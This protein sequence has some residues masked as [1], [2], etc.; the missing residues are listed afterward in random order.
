MAL[1]LAGE[2][3]LTIQ[4]ADNQGWVREITAQDALPGLKV[5]QQGTGRVFDFQD[6]G[7][8]KMYMPDGGDVT[9]AGSL[10]VGTI[11]PG[12]GDLTINPACDVDFS[13]NILRG[14]SQLRP[15]A[16]TA[17]WIV[18][19]QAL[20]PRRQHGMWSSSPLTPPLTPTL[21]WPAAVPTA[22]P[23]TPYWAQRADVT[24]PIDPYSSGQLPYV[25]VEPG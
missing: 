2:P 6:G 24:T 21:R 11:A 12:T 7:V 14:V 15:P 18:G 17:L 16:N 13:N 5:D 4:G 3:F 10:D 22:T 23:T 9:I 19:N 25:Q 20:T 8:S 1:R